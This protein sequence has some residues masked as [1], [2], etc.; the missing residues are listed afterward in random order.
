MSTFVALFPRA[1]AIER[2]RISG[3]SAIMPSITRCSACVL[4]CCTKPATMP[5]M[6]PVPTPSSSAESEIPSDTRPPR[7]TRVSRSRPSWSVPSK[8]G[9]LNPR[10]MNREIVSIVTASNLVSTGP[11]MTAAKMSTNSTAA[12]A[13]AGSSWMNRRR[14]C[15]APE[16]GSATTCGA[17]SRLV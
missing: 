11:T 9:V 16:R 4:Q 3:G 1:V 8:C 14:V 5:R 7:S 12:T 17:G 15:T 13:P 6:D 10:G 2:A